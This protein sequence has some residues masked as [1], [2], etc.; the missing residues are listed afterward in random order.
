M[1]ISRI[2]IHAYLKNNEYIKNH[3]DEEKKGVEGP[4]YCPLC[5]NVEEL[6]EHLLNYCSFKGRSL[7]SKYLYFCYW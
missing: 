4:C 6:M 7:G 2:H 1:S 3:G 5:V